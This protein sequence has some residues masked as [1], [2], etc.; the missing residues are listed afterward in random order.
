MNETVHPQRLPTTPPT[1]R[2]SRRE[3]TIHGQTLRDDYY[4]LRGKT[5]PEVIRHLEGIAATRAQSRSN[6]QHLRGSPS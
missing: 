1:A 4:W 2:R 6:G 3:T 5:D